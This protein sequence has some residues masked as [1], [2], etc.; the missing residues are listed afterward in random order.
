MEY[1]DGVT[2]QYKIAGRPL[3]LEETLRYAIEIVDALDVA[4]AA[5]I[6]HRDIKAANV[7][8]TNRGQAKVLDFGLA[9][10]MADAQS[11]GPD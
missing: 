6:I 8:I 7:L 2:L 10:L 3:D 4:H 11:G 1:L 9:K 5:G